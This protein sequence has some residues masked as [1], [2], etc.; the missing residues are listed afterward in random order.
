MVTGWWRPSYRSL[1]LGSH[2]SI[3]YTVYGILYSLFAIRYTGMAGHIKV[4]RVSYFNIQNVYF[5]RRRFGSSPTGRGWGGTYEEKKNGMGTTT[6]PNAFMTSFLGGGAWFYSP[7]P[8]LWIHSKTEI[9]NKSFYKQYFLEWNLF[10]HY[11]RLII[12]IIK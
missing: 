10:P 4:A 12:R 9:I 1:R 5:R 8:A 3:R 2:R 11:Y 7:I 6:L